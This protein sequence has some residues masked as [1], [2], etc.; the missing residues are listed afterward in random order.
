MLLSVY[1]SGVCYIV[2]CYEIPVKLSSEKVCDI[3]K[4]YFKIIL[5]NV[6]IKNTIKKDLKI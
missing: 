4:V 1:E 5:R 3:P 6:W 2:Y